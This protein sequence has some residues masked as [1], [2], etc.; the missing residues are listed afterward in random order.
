MCIVVSL[1]LMIEGKPVKAEDFFVSPDG[2]DRQSGTMDKPFRTINKGMEAAAAGDTVYLRRG[3]YAEEVSF[4]KAGTCTNRITLTSY[5]NETVTVQRA[6][7]VMIIDRPYITVERIVFDAQ[8]SNSDAVVVKSQGDYSILRGLEIK[9]TRK[10]ALDIRSPVGVLV[11]NCT[12]HDAVNYVDGERYDAHGIVTE[13]VQDLIIRGSEIYYVSGDALQFQYNNWK[14]IIVEDCTLWNGPLPSARGGAPAGVNPGEDGVDTK[15]NPPERGRLTIKNTVAHGWRGDRINNPAAFNIKHNVEVIFDGI[16]A[17]DNK[18]AF[19]LRGPGSQGGA[20]VTIKNAVIFDS[21]KAIRYEDDIENLDIYNS[22][23]GLGVDTILE[24]AASDNSV[25][26]IKNSLFLAETKPPEASDGSNMSADESVFVNA[27]EHDYHLAVGSAA[28]DAGVELTDVRIDRDKISRPQ[29]DGYD[30]G[31]Y[32]LNSSGGLS[33]VIVILQMLAGIDVYI[34]M[35]YD[36]NSDNTIGL[37][38]AVHILR[39]ISE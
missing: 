10:D 27:A 22:T 8:W 12:I 20:W 15:Y 9:N 34:D 5:G 24:E 4:P 26:N 18:N 13:G 17:Y 30:I 33:S 19:R 29:G 2:A 25:I 31:A 38:D 35:R 3:V 14:N 28:V 1:C 32:E 37:E 6:G 11:E 39:S 16:T 36:F 23:F 7:R 21:D